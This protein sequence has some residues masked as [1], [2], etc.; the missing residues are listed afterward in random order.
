VC[1][2]SIRHLHVCTPLF[3]L[4]LLLRQKKEENTELKDA[5]ELQLYHRKKM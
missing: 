2:L 4:I 5:K 3:S 1:G